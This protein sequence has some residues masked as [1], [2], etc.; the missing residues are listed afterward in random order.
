MHRC[1]TYLKIEAVLSSR[2]K[3]TKLHQPNYLKRLQGAQFILMI[4]K[5]AKSF[6]WFH[7]NYKSSR[8]LRTLGTVNLNRERFSPAVRCKTTKF[9]FTKSKTLK[10][11][12]T[13]LL[14]TS[15]MP[16]CQSVNFYLIN[17]GWRIQDFKLNWGCNKLPNRVTLKHVFCFVLFLFLFLF[18][19]FMLW[20][21]PRRF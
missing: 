14:I 2:Q 12:F 21:L 8:K 5:F 6:L 16:L 7:S 13:S 17:Q 9:T 18:L 11:Y 4:Y 1:V 10:I 15:H 19:F 3:L 20:K